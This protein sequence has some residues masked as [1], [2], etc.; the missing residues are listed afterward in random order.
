MEQSKYLLHF[1]QFS[2]YTFR[3]SLF[4]ILDKNKGFEQKR[5]GMHYSLPNSTQDLESNCTYYKDSKHI[6]YTTP[7]K[8]K[9]Q[10]LY[11]CSHF[12]SDTL[13]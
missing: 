12:Y 1:I 2:I 4:K 10:V 7:F 9:V 13:I 8:T 5:V 11:V 3:P 6:L